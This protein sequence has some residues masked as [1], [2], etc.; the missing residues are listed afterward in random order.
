MPEPSKLVPYRYA[1]IRLVPRVDRE[2]FINAGVIV[3]ASQHKLLHAAMRLREDRIRV[4]WPEL[5]LEPILR[6][7]AM[8]PRIC[9]GEPDAGPIAKLSQK[10]RFHWLTAPRSTVIQ[11]SPVRSGLTAT[12]E[13]LPD[14]LLTEYV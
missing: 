3:F 10:E 14:E 5:D 7:L 4:L 6:H 2:E 8:I 13:K 9:A 12:P 1:V 11:V